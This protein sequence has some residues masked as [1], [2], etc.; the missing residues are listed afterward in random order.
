MMDRFRPRRPESLGLI[1]NYDCTNR[2]A[3]CLYACSP[4]APS[5]P[6]VEQ[7]ERLVDAIA[8][9]APEAPLHVGG[10][11]PLLHP[12]RLER[13]VRRMRGAGLTLEYVET[14][15]FWVRRSGA[16]ALLE[17][18]RD[19]GCRRLLLSISPFHN[20]F[21]PAD[22]VR[23]AAA[24]IY[25]VFGPDGLFAWHAAYMPYLE[26]VDPA[27][28][29]PFDAYAA[30][31][32]P[33][34]LIHQLQNVIYLHPAGRAAPTFARYLPRRPAAAF[35]GHPC[36]AALASPIHAHVDP[37]GR[38]LTGF[39]AGIQVGDRAAFDLAGLVRDG[40]A[41]ELHPILARLVTGGLGALLDH[42]AA[43]GFVPLATGYVSACHVCLHLR[44]FLRAHPDAEPATELAP[45]FFYEDLAPAFPGEQ[46]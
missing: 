21:L 10:G 27:R 31:F 7:L 36:A 43:L 24:L 4:A 38:Y 35:R 9:A 32:E 12:E 13:V 41:L 33:I 46:R 14:N 40:V 26:T 29:V 25:E 6:P 8:A 1:A 2:C 19:A 22:R 18:L 15:G 42:G 30:A 5:P 20:E 28:T 45:D 11:E 16:R 23:E 17:R 3:H 37:D 39:C 34:S 44:S